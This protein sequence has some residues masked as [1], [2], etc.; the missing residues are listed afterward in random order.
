M[1]SELKASYR[2]PGC[3]YDD[4][5]TIIIQDSVIVACEKCLVK[6]GGKYNLMSINEYLKMT[7][8][9]IKYYEAIGDKATKLSGN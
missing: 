5:R 4:V 8:R 2:C 6:N 3:G 1:F 7:E 9:E